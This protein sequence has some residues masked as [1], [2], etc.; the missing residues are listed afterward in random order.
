MAKIMPLGNET[1]IVWLFNVSYSVGPGCPNCRDDVLLV[2]H[3]INCVM[4]PL[5]LKNPKGE[6]IVS[7]LHR[8]GIFGPRTAEAILAYQQSVKERGRYITVDGR[9][10]S[11]PKSGWTRH[12]DAQYTIVYLNRDNRD[13]NGKMMDEKDFPAELQRAIKRNSPNY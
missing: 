6:L 4:A 7:Y 2:Q 1:D 9:V 13:I 10:D 5:H 11:T 3:A 12:G 8:D